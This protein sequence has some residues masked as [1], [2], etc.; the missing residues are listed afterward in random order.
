MDNLNYMEAY[1]NRELPSESE[2]EFE[3]KITGDPAFAEEVAFYLSSRQ[4]AA[5]EMMEQKE[6]LK[7]VYEQYKQGKHTNSHQPA[8][9]R[10]FFPWVA[11]AAV[12]AGIIFGLNVWFKPG[13]PGELADKYML[14]NFQNLPVKMDIARDSLQTA[15]G[16]Y[17][18]GRTEEALKKLESIVRNDTTFSEAKK[19]A[20]IVSL[21]VGQYDK[22]IDYFSQL[23]NHTGLY[24][25]PGTFYHALTL[26][27]RNRPG[28]KEAAKLLLVQV[29]QNDMEEKNVAQK[30]LRKW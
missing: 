27:K 20:G 14:E 16:M 8:I 25:N 2:R 7:V 5:A 29:V 18:E 1:F 23:A 19:Y 15:L 28:D 6:R 10:R 13:S 11:A 26:L 12:L 21:R 9:L 30:W 3:Q 24:A 17:N 22:A 4:A